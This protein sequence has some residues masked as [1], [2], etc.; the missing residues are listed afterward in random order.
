MV[1]GEAEY[2]AAQAK[3]YVDGV[4]DRVAGLSVCLSVRQRA[5]R[6]LVVRVQGFRRRGS[7]WG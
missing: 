6:I 3:Q 7:S 4:A 2:N 5:Y 1:V